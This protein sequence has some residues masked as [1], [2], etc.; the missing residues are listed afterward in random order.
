M[1]CAHIASAFNLPM[2]TFEEVDGSN[3]AVT[4]GDSAFLPQLLTLSHFLPF[5]SNAYQA[6]LHPGLESKYMKLE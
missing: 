5:H 6:C 4:R 2:T 3:A 1:T